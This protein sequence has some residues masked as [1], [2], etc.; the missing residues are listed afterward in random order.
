MVGKSR[1]RL[2][3]SYVRGFIDGRKATKNGKGSE[4]VMLLGHAGTW[5]ERSRD[6]EEV[7]HH[8]FDGQRIRN[9]GP[10]NRRRARVEAFG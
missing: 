4:R 6:I 2:I 3:R 5:A 1:D 7:E 10:A 9:E 8:V